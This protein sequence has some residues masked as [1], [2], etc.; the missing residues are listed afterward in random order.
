MPETLIIPALTD[1]KAD[2]EALAPQDRRR[3]VL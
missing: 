3:W 1:P 2:L